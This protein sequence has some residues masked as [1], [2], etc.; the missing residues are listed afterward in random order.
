MQPVPARPGFVDEEELAAALALE[1]AEQRVDVALTHT[2]GADRHG[3]GRAVIAG[4]RHGDRV[5]VYVHADIP[6]GTV[7]HG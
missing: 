7:S 1:L 2:D 3:L 6:C 5:L 4:V